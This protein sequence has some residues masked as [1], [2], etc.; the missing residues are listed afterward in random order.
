MTA[1]RGPT[2]TPTTG[3]VTAAG[4]YTAH[5][6]PSEGI[7]CQVTAS[8]ESYPSVVGRA[9]VP[10]QPSSEAIGARTV[11]RR[12]CQVRRPCGIM[13]RKGLAQ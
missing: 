3:T 10:F 12:T 1:P 13:Q 4:Q 5:A 2:I 11:G 9:T 8:L 7:E 6:S